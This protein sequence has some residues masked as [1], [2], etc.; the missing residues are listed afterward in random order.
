MTASVT[1]NPAT[2]ESGCL[3]AVPGR[4]SEGL[5]GEE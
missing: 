1:I 5:V 2:V 3:E 4:H